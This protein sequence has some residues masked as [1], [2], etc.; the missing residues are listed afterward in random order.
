MGEL[1]VPNQWGNHNF[2][3]F[4]STKNMSETRQKNKN[5]NQIKFCIP[6]AY[7]S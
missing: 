7:I 5:Y 1:N 3:D 4:S 2:R 6:V